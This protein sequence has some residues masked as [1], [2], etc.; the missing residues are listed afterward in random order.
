MPKRGLIILDID[1][2]L[3][4]TK[5]V[6]NKYKDKLLGRSLK[7]DGTYVK[8]S[9]T[10]S[11]R[12]ISKLYNKNAEIVPFISVLIYRRPYLTQFLT[13]I[14]QHFYVAI[15]TAANE[16][17]MNIV[18]NKVLKNY[19]DKFLFK[20]NREH[21][22]PEGKYMKPLRR[23]FDKYPK[24]NSYNTLIIDDNYTTTKIKISH[25]HINRFDYKKPDDHLKVIT[26]LLKKQIKNKYFNPR[27]IIMDYQEEI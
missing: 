5:I 24:F 3:I 19:K 21:S 8:P 23:I 13:Y 7:T 26:D 4:D 14:F 2:T 11:K 1:N 9:I 17:W 27:E 16:E 6:L 20:W 22:N 18:L 15:W 12:D 10:L 25:L